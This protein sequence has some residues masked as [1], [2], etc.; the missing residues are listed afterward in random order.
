M[1]AL[2]RANKGREAK[3]L[4][5]KTKLPRI[6]IRLGKWVNY[7]QDMACSLLIQMPLIQALLLL[8]ICFQGLREFK[9]NIPCP[10]REPFSHK[11]R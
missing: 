3:L 9:T 10:S 1:E 4:L 11:H 5:L 6:L 8:E 7:R 2:E